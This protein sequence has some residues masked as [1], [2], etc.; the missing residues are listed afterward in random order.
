MK[1]LML[2]ILAICCGTRAG[3]FESDLHSQTTAVDVFE[4]WDSTGGEHNLDNA[5]LVAVHLMG[6]LSDYDAAKKFIADNPEYSMKV[7]AL[8]SSTGATLC[9]NSSV[10]T[11]NEAFEYL[12]KLMRVYDQFGGDTYRLLIQTYAERLEIRNQST[13]EYAAWGLTL[14]IEDWELATYN[15]ELYMELKD[16]V[17]SMTKDEVL[18]ALEANKPDFTGDPDKALWWGLYVTSWIK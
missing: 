18:T 5:K 1:Y 6:H 8:V 7:H 12:K 13:A 14:P 2:V 4:L 16:Q 10:Y 3:G 15:I 17:T 9:D 11:D